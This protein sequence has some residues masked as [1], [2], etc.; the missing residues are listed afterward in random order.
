MLTDEQKKLLCDVVEAIVDGEDVE[1]KPF[2][3]WLPMCPSSEVLNMA[4]YIKDGCLRVKPKTVTIG[5][6]AVPDDFIRDVS[7]LEDGQLFYVENANR[8]DY[9][10]RH[11]Y[12]GWEEDQI[13]IERNAAHH[14]EEGA[15][16]ACMARYGIDPES[17]E[18]E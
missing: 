3:E 14:T 13:Y 10:S 12:H 4:E 18:G 5:D 1:R 2:T 7:E 11:V 6:Y 16:A 17:W 9:L 8:A 15:R